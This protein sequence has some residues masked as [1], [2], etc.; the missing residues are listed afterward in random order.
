MTDEAIKEAIYLLN[1]VTSK[2]NAIDVG[3][4][5]KLNK[6]THSIEREVQYNEVTTVNILIRAAYETSLTAKYLM[7]MEDPSNYDQFFETDLMAAKRIAQAFGSLHHKNESD[8]DMI[9]RIKAYV[10]AGG[11]NYNNLSANVPPSWHKVKSYPQLAKELDDEE[12]NQI[13]LIMGFGSQSVHPNY[14][15]LMQHH[16]IDT[17]GDGT[18]FYPKLRYEPLPRLTVLGMAMCF[19]L[20]ATKAFFGKYATDETL[21]EAVTR[22]HQ[23]MHTDIKEAWSN[24]PSPH[25][26]GAKALID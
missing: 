20:T 17:K 25:V 19:S 10:K 21:A 24:P 9:Q 16:I 4:M 18:Y 2:E 23:L 1:D 7:R 12:F 15:D 22:L 26:P 6:L 13:R 3:L 14:S 11:Y 8:K 5:V